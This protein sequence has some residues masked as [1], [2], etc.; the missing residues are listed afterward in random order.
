ML[1]I[2]RAK[3]GTKVGVVCSTEPSVNSLTGL[4]K[5]NNADIEVHSH[6]MTDKDGLERFVAQMDLIIDTMSTHQFVQELVADN[7]VIT[8]AF[9]INDQS[10]DFL[11]TSVFQFVKEKI[12]HS[13]A[14]SL[15]DSPP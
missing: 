11:K 8:I 9:E 7:S 6:L 1:Q 2:A 14:P 10:L 15:S 13:L 12:K 3:K 5:S 4:V